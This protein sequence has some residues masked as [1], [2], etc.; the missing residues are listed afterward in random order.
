MII[1]KIIL[2]EIKEI[3]LKEIKI[4]FLLSIHK[5]MYHEKICIMASSTNIYYQHNGFLIK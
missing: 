4:F 2:K 5:N 1:K 3:I